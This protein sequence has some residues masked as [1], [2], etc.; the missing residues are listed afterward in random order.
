MNTS[1]VHA[2]ARFWNQRSSLPSRSPS[3]AR[4]VRGRCI[5][6]ERSLRGIRAPS[7]I[8]SLRRFD[9]QADAVTLIQLFAEGGQK[10][11]HQNA[12][13]VSEPPHSSSLPCLRLTV[14][15]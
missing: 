10:L 8:I 4:R 2:G 13:R 14:E 1:S 5:R 11:E 3:Y 7:A 12:V 15:R 9:G 6:V